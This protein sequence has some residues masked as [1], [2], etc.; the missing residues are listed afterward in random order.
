MCIRDS[1]NT[2]SG[3]NKT[4]T[5]NVDETASNLVEAIAAK[6]IDSVVGIK[7]TYSLN[8]FFGSQQ[9][10][11]EGSGVIY[12][13]DGYK[14]CIRDRAGMPPQIDMTILYAVIGG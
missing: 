1:N 9:A 12:S 4:T 5:I 14:M 11:S 7:T 2:A 3:G 10:S 13:A 6:C 8:Q